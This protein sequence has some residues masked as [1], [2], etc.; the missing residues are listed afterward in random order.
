L[1]QLALDLPLMT[2]EV[3]KWYLPRVM[4]DSL[5]H[6][7][8]GKFPL[9][10]VEMVIFAFDP[11]GTFRERNINAKVK[12]LYDERIRFLTG[13]NDEQKRAVCNWLDRV[14]TSPEVKSYFRPFSRIRQ[15]FGATAR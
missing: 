6:I 2:E 15:R 8:V 4:C 1:E 14:S 5:S 7:A 11:E 10:Q 9:T 12:L 3:E 13:F